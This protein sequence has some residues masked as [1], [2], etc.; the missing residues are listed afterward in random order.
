M[1][2]FFT[3]F[4][5]REWIGCLPE[6]VVEV[7]GAGFVGFVAEDYPGAAVVGFAGGVGDEAF[8]RWAVR[9]G[10]IVAWGRVAVRVCD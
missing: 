10:G 5:E 9:H 8:W 2:G 1:R 3:V 6:I 4:G 7:V